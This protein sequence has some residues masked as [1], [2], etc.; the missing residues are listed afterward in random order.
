MQPS[1]NES[2]VVGRNLAEATGRAEKIAAGRKFT[3]EQ[4]D[5]V[6]DTWF[7]SG[8]WPFAIMGWPD[9]VGIT[10][11]RISFV[12]HDSTNYH[13]RTHLLLDRRPP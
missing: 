2:W 5:D 10:P 6:L 12:S 13:S 4:D 8:L 3:L 1:N 11:A 7:S 9:K